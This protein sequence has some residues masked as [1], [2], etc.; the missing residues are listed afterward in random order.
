M[1]NS[2]LGLY[3]LNQY[4]ECLA[5]GFK[6]V[7]ECIFLISLKWLTSVALAL[8]L[9]ILISRERHEFS[10][11]MDQIYQ[12]LDNINRLRNAVLPWGFH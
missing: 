8:S 5:T 12:Y 2:V 10:I 3:I 6:E 9:I 1:L 7:S 4:G 11:L